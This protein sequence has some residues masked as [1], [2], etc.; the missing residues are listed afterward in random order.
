M[1]SSSRHYR[2]AGVC[3]TSQ[4]QLRAISLVSAL[5][6]APSWLVK[7]SSALPV[8]L[9][10]LKTAPQKSAARIECLYCSHAAVSGLTNRCILKSSFRFQRV[11]RMF[12]SSGSHIRSLK[13]FGS[14]LRWQACGASFVTAYQFALLANHERRK[15]GCIKGVL[16]QF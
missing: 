8:C 7:H 13:P 1:P 6:A 9:V 16:L 10:A 14:P 2:R 3:F 4:K 11:L 5:S 15:T 12:L